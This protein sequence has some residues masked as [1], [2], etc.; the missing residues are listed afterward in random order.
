MIIV[1]IIKQ[2]IKPSNCYICGKII[3]TGSTCLASNGFDYD[4][5]P[6]NEHAHGIPENC[7]VE[8][9]KGVDNLDDQE[10]INGFKRDFE[11]LAK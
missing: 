4:N 7:F 2:T 6:V 8:Y 1:K 10:T 9:L 5:N 11:D 3:P